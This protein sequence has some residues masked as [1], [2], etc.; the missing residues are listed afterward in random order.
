VNRR[1]LV[2][3]LALAPAWAQFPHAVP[4]GPAASTAKVP[5]VRGAATGS[6]LDALE[7]DF[8]DKLAVTGLTDRIMVRG[9]TRG[10]RLDDYGAVFTAEVDLVATPT[11][12]MFQRVIKPEQVAEVHR[13][14][15]DNLAVLRKAMREMMTD[16]AGALTSLAPEGHIVVAVRLLYQSWED[17]TGLPSE[18]LMKASRQSAQAGDIQTDER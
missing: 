11:I 14:K 5:P 16:S 1:F 8:D 4:G 3:A 6:G 15:L 17:H 18:I 9:Y 13:R 10:L 12:N 7:R 2:F